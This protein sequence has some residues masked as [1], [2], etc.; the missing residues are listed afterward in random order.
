MP[1]RLM[2]ALLILAIALPAAAQDA[3]PAK[4]PAGDGVQKPAPKGD[5]ALIKAAGKDEKVR[6][7]KP[8]DG[9]RSRRLRL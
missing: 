3:E 4:P 8:K 2:F 9:I 6:V 7:L 5:G 1:C